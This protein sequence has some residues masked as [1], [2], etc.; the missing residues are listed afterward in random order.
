MVSNNL[1]IELGI[2]VVFR[3]EKYFL[4]KKNN[5]EHFHNMDL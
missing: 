3:Q 5:N 2:Y 1:K 4:I